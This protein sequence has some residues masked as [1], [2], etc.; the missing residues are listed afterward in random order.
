MSNAEKGVIDSQSIPHANTD[1]DMESRMSALEQEVQGLRQEQSKNLSSKSSH[2]IT[3]PNS[4][5]HANAGER[6]PNIRDVIAAEVQKA[7]K[8][9]T[10]NS[11]NPEPS[12]TIS[13]FNRSTGSSPSSPYHPDRTRGSSR[14]LDSANSYHSA[15]DKEKSPGCKSGRTKTS[16]SKKSCNY[17]YFVSCKPS[18]FTGTKGAI[19]TMKW[20]AEIEKVVDISDCSKEDVIR[21]VSQSFKEEAMFWWKTILQARGKEEVYGLP[22]EEFRA[23][24]QERFCQPYEVENI[25]MEFLNLRMDGLQCR[26]YTT[27]FNELAELVPHLVTPESQRISR[28]LNGLSKEIQGLTRASNPKTYADAVRAAYAQTEVAR[29]YSVQKENENSKRKAPSAPQAS[30]RN[31]KRKNSNGL[32]QSCSKCGNFHKGACAKNPNAKLCSICHFYG[33]SVDTCNK[34]KKIICYGCGESG[35]LRSACK[36]KKQGNGGSN[37]GG[38][39]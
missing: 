18:D 7:M 24:V 39:E 23:L 34:L 32:K 22:W 19:D 31:R 38:A 12:R 25:E 28:Y 37:E 13:Q 30:V 14:T 9:F 21:F 4:P 1:T 3:H 6:I 27:R 35:H 20:L 26:E 11:Q 29:R 36:K 15:P 17:K 2:A 8:G 16:D 33:H 10:P 5:T